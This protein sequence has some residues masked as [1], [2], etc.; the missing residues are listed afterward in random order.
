MF[1]NVKNYRCQFFLQRGFYVPHGFLVSS[2]SVVE[3]FRF[4]ETSK[5][6]ILVGRYKVLSPE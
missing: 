5:T 4:S 6:L 1:K 3:Q 2:F